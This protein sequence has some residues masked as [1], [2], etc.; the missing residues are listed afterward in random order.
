MQSLL[1]YSPCDSFFQLLQVM[2]YLTVESANLSASC[3]A[4][5][6]LFTEPPRLMRKASVRRKHKS[7]LSAK[8]RKIS[9]RKERP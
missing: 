6:E 8:I 3:P 5:T 2:N 4:L 9:T 7:G 1:E